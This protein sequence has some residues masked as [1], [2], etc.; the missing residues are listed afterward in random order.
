MIRVS[1]S[2][3]GEIIIDAALAGIESRARDMRPAWPAVLQAFRVAVGRAFATEGSSTGAPWA[4][5]A[6]STQAERVRLGF[7]AA[8][9][10]LH[11]T[12]KLERALTI[13]EGS[14][15]S[16]GATSLALRLSSEVGYFKYHQSASPRTHL[17]RRA[18]VLLTADDRTQIL[19][20]IRLYLSGRALGGVRR[21]DWKDRG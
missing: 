16:T 14:Y 9:P 21:P 5:L 17:P 18:P 15:A 12:G 6:K 13:G 10:I 4:P 1:L 20:P 3:E 11:R 2:L 19:N 7:G 8:H